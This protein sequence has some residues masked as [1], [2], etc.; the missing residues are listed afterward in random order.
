MNKTMW[1]HK[2]TGLLM[3]FILLATFTRAQKKIITIEKCYLLARQNYPLIKK[4]DLIAR[5]SSYSIENAGKF[6]LP[7]FSVSGQATY[8][9]Q[10]VDFQKAIGGGPGILIPPLSKDQYKIQAEV[11]QTIY[12]GGAI[13]NQRE[14]IMASTASQQQSLEVSL[15]SLYDRINQLYFSI[16]LMDEQIRQ[17]NINKDNFRSSAEKAKA[18]YDNGTGMKSSVDE[19]LAEIATTEMTNIDL[20][21]GRKAYSDML[22]VFIGQPIGEGAELIMPPQ[23]ITDPVI[24]RPELLM[25]DLNKKVY[26][27]QEK[28]LKS[29]YLPKINAFVQGAYGRP[30]L[31]FIDNDFGAWWIGGIRMVWNLGSLYTLKNN[32]ANLKINKEFQDVD[33]ETFIYNTNLSLSK[34]SQDMIKYTLLLK[35]DETLISLRGSVA[36]AAKAQLDNG[37]ITI[38]D[39]ISKMNEENLALQSKI[40]HSVQLLQAQY[41]YQN[42]TGN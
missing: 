36:N 15:Y 10:T 11:D 29:E 13:N 34:Q 33:R 38:H 30:T 37:V 16:L 41:Q 3:G 24:R 28:Q 9:S 39:Y 25:Y 1:F 21:A 40:L 17:N 20:N 4:H 18:A 31:N 14:M 42:T 8:Q 26:D 5:S 22:S 35:Q 2:L 27:V 7:Q 19:F 32:Q 12:D 6:Y 23:V